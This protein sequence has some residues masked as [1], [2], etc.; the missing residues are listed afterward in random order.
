MLQFEHQR[1]ESCR[2]ILLITTL[3]KACFAK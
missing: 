3:F 2:F 1:R